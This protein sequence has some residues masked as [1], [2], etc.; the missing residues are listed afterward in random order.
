MTRI[1]PNKLWADT[2]HFFRH[3][4]IVEALDKGESILFPGREAKVLY[5]LRRFTPRLLWWMV[6]KAE[7]ES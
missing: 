2:V 6:K 3:Q 5:G 4:V 7:Y 1:R